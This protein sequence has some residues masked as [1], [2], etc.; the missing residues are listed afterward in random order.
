MATP[1]NSPGLEKGPPA[2]P[3]IGT[4]L[5]QILASAEGIQCHIVV[6]HKALV[7]QR[8]DCDS[9]IAEVLR[10]SVSFPLDDL[11][12]RLARLATQCD[13]KPLGQQYADADAPKGGS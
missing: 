9:D 11:R 3:D 5:R 10:L 7:E 4:E 8:A 2:L 1:D 6:C 12:I 13:G